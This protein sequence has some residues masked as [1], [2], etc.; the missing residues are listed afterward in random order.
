MEEEVKPVQDSIPPVIPPIMKKFAR[1]GFKA[2]WPYIL[3]SLLVVLLGVGTGWL[4]SGKA[5]RTGTAGKVDTGAKVSS[6]EAGV[7]D[8]ATFSQTAEGLLEAG[9][10][11]GEGTYHLTRDGGPS[12][13]V[14]LTSTVIDLEAFVGKKV[15]IWGE[16]LTS[17]G[18]WLM[19]VGKIKVVE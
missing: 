7:E 10:V 6:N 9:G 19:D 1:P 2:V 4:L 17:R 8:A 15:T 12:Q 14:R 16:T 3:G 18:G 5:V 11:N 13:T